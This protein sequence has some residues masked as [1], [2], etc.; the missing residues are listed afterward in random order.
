MSQVNLHGKVASLKRELSETMQS[1]RVLV[2]QLLRWPVIA[3]LSTVLLFVIV[4]LE[5]HA[6]FGILSFVFMISSVIYV[7]LAGIFAVAFVVHILRRK[8]ISAMSALLALS[9]TVV[10]V[11]RAQAITELTF[12]IIDTVRFSVSQNYYLQI[13]ANQKDQT[14]RFSWGSGGFLATNFFYTLIY[15]PDGSP[16]VPVSAKHQGCSVTLSKLRKNFYIE[17]EICQ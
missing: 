5:Q 7:G 14:Q 6:D 2:V 16:S 17:S 15:L 9:M 13:V 8:F 1:A 4:Y 12:Q 3:A 11:A 10:V